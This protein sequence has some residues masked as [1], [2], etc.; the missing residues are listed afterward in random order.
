MPP[1]MCAGMAGMQA[2]APLHRPDWLAACL[3][4]NHII[5]GKAMGQKVLRQAHWLCCQPLAVMHCMRGRENC[6]DDAQPRNCT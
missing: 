4:F 2:H 5:C 3:L 1:S 6:Q